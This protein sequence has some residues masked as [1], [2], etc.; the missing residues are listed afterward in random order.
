MSNETRLNIIKSIVCG[1][2]AEQI[3]EFYNLSIDIIGKLI[4]DNEDEINRAKRL[5]REKE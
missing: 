1:Y 4:M 2:N 3:A 5:A